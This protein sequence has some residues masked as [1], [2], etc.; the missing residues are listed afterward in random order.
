MPSRIP[1]SSPNDILPRLGSGSPESGPASPWSA[2]NELRRAILSARGDD[3]EPEDDDG[4]DEVDLD[5]DSDGEQA[6]VPEAGTV[7]R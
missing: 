5:T 3:R 1:F 4:P 2:S 7:T 6:D